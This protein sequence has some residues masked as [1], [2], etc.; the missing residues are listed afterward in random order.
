MDI[1]RIES[2]NKDIEALNTKASKAEA[3]REM[4]KKNLMDSIKKYEDAYGV[5]LSGDSMVEIKKKLKAEYKKVYQDVEKE[6]DLADKVIRAINTGDV[7]LARELLGYEEEEE[8]QED[9]E[10]EEVEVEEKKEDAPEEKVEQP[11]KLEKVED[12]FFGLE[13]K[14]E[15]KAEKAPFFGF[16]DEEDGEDEFVTQP[17]VESKPKGVKSTK[18]KEVSP[19]LMSPPSFVVEDDDEDESPESL[20]FGGLTPDE[21]DEDEDEEDFYGGFGSVLAGTKFGRK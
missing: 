13:D 2:L 15:G 20:V 14:E 21:E 16:E 8:T 6:A 9:P 11:V 1:K 12:A 19:N 10:L 18:T 7:A 5:D 17:T 4:L 3:Q